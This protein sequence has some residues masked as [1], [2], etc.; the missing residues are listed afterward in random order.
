MFYIIFKNYKYLKRIWYKF[1]K[2]YSR[3][4]LNYKRKREK[5]SLW[6]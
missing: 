4:L 3:L 5:H 6:N 1:E 2:I